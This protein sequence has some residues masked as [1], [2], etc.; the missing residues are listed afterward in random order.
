MINDPITAPIHYSGN[1]KI[2]AKDA[3]ESMMAHVSLTPIEAYWWGCAFK[4]LWRW[5]LKNK[6]QDLLK[7]AQCL[8]YL[9]E[10]LEV[11]DEKTTA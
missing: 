9:I 4:Y 8:D 3:M 10:E 7:C 5:P 2:E 11:D 6:K 1:G